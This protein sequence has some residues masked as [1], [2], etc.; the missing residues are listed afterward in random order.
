MRALSYEP[1]ERYASVA[2]LKEDVEAFQ[3]GAWDVP[4]VT[5]AAGSII[6]REGEA[7]DAAYV[8]LEGHCA[9]YQVEGDQEVELR[10]M[11]PGEVFGETAVFSNKPRTASVRATTDV[12]LLMVTGEILQKTLGLN[13]WM[14]AFVKALADRFREADQKLRDAGRGSGAQPSKSKV[15]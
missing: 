3:R 13:S 9:A 5:W 14:G 15:P 2:S 8:I 10:V 6:I 7:G 12:V 11:G 1:S 4:R